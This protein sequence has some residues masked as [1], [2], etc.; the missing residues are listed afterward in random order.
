MANVLIWIQF[1]PY[2]DVYSSSF[3]DALLSGYRLTGMVSVLTGV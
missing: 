2:V 3:T 1:K